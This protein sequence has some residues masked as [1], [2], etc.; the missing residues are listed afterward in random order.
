MEE[1]QT[2]FIPAAE[3]ITKALSVLLQEH[4]DEFG[5]SKYNF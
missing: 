1:L 5:L 2:K 3:E 4:E